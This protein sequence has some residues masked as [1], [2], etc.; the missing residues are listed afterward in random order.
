MNEVLNDWLGGE[1]RQLTCRF[2]SG[3]RLHNK[4]EK[5]IRKVM[6]KYRDDFSIGGR[7]NTTAS[8]INVIMNADDPALYDNVMSDLIGIYRN[9]DDAH[10]TNLLE[11][12]VLNFIKTK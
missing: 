9:F 3:S 11:G 10:D 2:K 4:L 12:F 1:K 6:S 7:G 5:D 8:I